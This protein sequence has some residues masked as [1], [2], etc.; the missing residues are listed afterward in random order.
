MREKIYD[1]IIV[2]GGPAGMTAGIYALRLG[3]KTLLITKE[4]GGQMA[5][6]VVA[7]EN[8]P[9]FL[10]ISG[11]ELIERMKEQLFKKGT[12]VKLAEVVGVEK[13]GE[14][15]SVL[16]KNNETFKAKTLIV[17][18]GAN[19]RS[20]SVPGEKEFL[21]RGVSY[22]AICD[23]PLFKDKVVAVIG[24][25][26]SGFESAIYL[27]KFANEIYILEYGEE[28]KADK[29]NQK[30]AKETGKVKVITRAAVKE[31]KGGKFVEGLVY[32]DRKS[33]KEIELPVSGIFIEI[34]LA[35]ATSFI[36]NLVDFNQK[37][38]I[39]V[40][41]ETYQTKTPGLF[42]AGDCNEGK[43]KQIVVACGEGAK[44][45]LAAYDYLQKLKSG[46]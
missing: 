13:E 4:F 17:A 36:K 32:Q 7:I 16:T 46:K 21:G 43:Y 29:E 19:P 38:E 1:L 9:G 27:A 44:A 22:C 15:F 26:N 25:G 2:G 6:K 37:G 45:A 5:K 39:L 40:E 8:Y 12:D 18:T 30:K 31:I 3:L 33:G 41:P 24:G 42:A 11:L 23:A 14:I 10:A 35:P 34:G 28:V 20:L